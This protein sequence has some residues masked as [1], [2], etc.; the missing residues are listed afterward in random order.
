MSGYPAAQVVHVGQPMAAPIQVQTQ[1]A[2]IQVQTQPY[3]QSAGYQARTSTINVFRT[4]T[5]V[6]IHV[7]IGVSTFS[8]SKTQTYIRTNTYL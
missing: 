7:F 4:F 5:H 1:P 2:P 3:A 8:P 6:G